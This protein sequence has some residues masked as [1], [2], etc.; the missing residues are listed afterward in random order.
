M[1]HLNI[2]ALAGVAIVLTVAIW[3]FLLFLSGLQL[4][5]TWLAFK[6]LPTVLTIEVVIWG[7]FAKWGWRY[8][9]FQGWLVPFPFL[10]GTWRGT[11]TST[12]L[13][14]E[15]RQ[16]VAPIKVVLV[17]RQTFLDIHCTILTQES[18][19]RSYFASI[20]IDTDSTEKRLV[21]SYNNKPRTVI[22]DQSPIHD[23]TA[24]FL[25]V[26]DPPKQLQG[27]YWTN[28]KT[29]GELFLRFASRSLAER[30]SE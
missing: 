22:R 15:T 20:H 28:R 12:W 19:N 27:E 21:Y 29:T 8:K 23:G 2:K 9:L 13:N 16:P 5:A 26:G 4:E 3:L 10:Q 25:V 18:E 17:I 11:L 7:L 24:S 14:P 6:Q 30:F 1:K